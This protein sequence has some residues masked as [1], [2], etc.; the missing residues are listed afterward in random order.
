MWFRD[1]KGIMVEIKRNDFNND[2]VYFTFIKSQLFDYK[3]PKESCVLDTITN[4]ISG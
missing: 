1:L 2:K 3:A 4:L